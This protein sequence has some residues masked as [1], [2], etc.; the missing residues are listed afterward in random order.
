[1][2]RIKMVAV[3]TLEEMQERLDF[4]KK[5][6]LPW[7]ACDMVTWNYILEINRTNVYLTYLDLGE[8]KYRVKYFF[9][10]DGTKASDDL[11]SGAQAFRNLQKMS[12][13]GIIDLSGEEFKG[14][15]WEEWDEE[16][17]KPIWKT[18][19]ASPIL[20]FNNKYNGQR[21]EN[22]VS[23][24]INSMYAYCLTMKMP[25]TS[26]K[27]RMFGIVNENE[28]GFNIVAKN[29]EERL[30]AVFEGSV[31]K[32][33]FPLIE[34]PF[35][36]FS[37]Y[38]YKKKKNSKSAKEKQKNKDVLNFAIGYILRK[39]PFI[40]CAILSYARDIIENLIDENTLYCNTDSIF[41]KTRRPEIEEN[42][43]EELGQWKI[44]HKGSLAILNG[45]YQWNEDIPSI[46]SIPKEW[47]R[48]MKEKDNGID[49]L[50]DKI[51]D[52]SFNKYIIDIN[53]LKIKINKNFG[54]INYD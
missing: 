33:I 47:L 25:D 6:K 54:G 44:D 37:N 46:R 26:V 24:D 52:E 45:K 22:C 31:A 30:K 9:K 38:Y 21:I 50:K 13:N 4:C 16:K 43:G 49:L 8:Y 28:I 3:D 39:N 14:I 19:Y 15:Y 1:M 12:N 53:E 10:L 2:K 51:P 34:S 11:V 32:Y 41:S 18:G 42:L 17:G 5:Y 27:P 36:R 40:H 48:R 7:Q 20:Y 23:Y 35:K 29:G